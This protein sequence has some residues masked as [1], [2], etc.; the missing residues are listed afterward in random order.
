MADLDK[1]IIPVFNTNY[2]EGVGFFVDDF[3]ITSGHVIC[4]GQPFIVINGK[5]LIL[6]SKDALLLTTLNEESTFD[7]GL[8]IAVFRLEGTLSPLAFT[9]TRIDVGTELMSRSVFRHFSEEYGE[10]LSLEETSGHVTEV[11]GNFFKCDLDKVLREGS[12]GSPIFNDNDVAGILCGNFSGDPENRILY[13]S[14][15]VINKL[16]RQLRK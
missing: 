4:E 8:D 3:F 10:A 12:S 1:Y 7:D 9:H 11:I 14:G 2:S 15:C 6:S 13:L 5:K 16:L